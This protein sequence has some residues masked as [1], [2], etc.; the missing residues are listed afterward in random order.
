MK[1]SSKLIRILAVLLCISLAA[2]A[3]F[4]CAKKETKIPGDCDNSGKVNAIDSNC[5][6]RLIGGENIT[7]SQINSDLNGDG[8]QNKADYSLMK[9]YLSGTYMPGMRFSEIFLNGTNIENYTIVI[10]K[11]NS[12]FEKWTAEILSSAIE[13]L[14]GAD[15]KVLT[16]DAE[17]GIYEILIG[18]TSRKESHDLTA[19]NRQ[20]LLYS[21]GNKIILKGKDY[22]VAGGAGDIIASLRNSDTEWNST[23]Y[24][25]I[26]TRTEA[27]HVKWEKPDNILY[28]IGDGMGLNHTKMA[29]DDV[30]VVEYAG[31]TFAS[32]DEKGC[33]VFWPSTFENIGDAVTLNYQNST[34][35]SAAGATALSTG[36]KTL[37]GALGMIPA[38]LDGDGE[39]NEYQSVQNV[40]EAACLAGKATAVL[41]TDKQTGATPNAFLIHHTSR[42]D[43]NIILEQQTALDMT[44]LACNYLWCSYDSDEA[45]ENFKEAID[46]CDDNL[47]GF[48]IMTEEAMIDKYGEKMDYD[49]VI[50]T[51]KRL[52]E[53]TAY[54][55]TYAVCHTN[56]V[57]I[58]TA[59][60]ETGG[61]VY[62]EDEIW[63]WTSNGEHTGTNVPVFAM[64]YETDR[65]KDVTCDNTEIAEFLFDAVK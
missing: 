64:G 54:A 47:G 48:F 20:Y 43:R 30:A 45:L 11:E 46:V 37:N 59:D 10:P 23:A 25:D 34:T 1:R 5:L 57:V 15:L 6:Q 13:S 9:K 53:M 7:L 33:E 62:G 52:N 60:H 29:T 42:Q 26:S 28:F 55:A 21:K 14:C 32:A 16:D 19:A 8:I 58:L 65:F 44:R 40:R 17:V 50:R 36:H 4:S 61:L 27:L 18:K 51:V 63:R 35:D 41:S 3:F 22:Y 56:T 24:L 12:Q 31:G 38:D 49:N 2:T 39:K